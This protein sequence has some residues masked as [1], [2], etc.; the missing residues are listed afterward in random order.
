MKSYTEIN[1][2]RIIADLERSGLSR[3]E[4]YQSERFGKFFPEGT[5]QP[6]WSTFCNYT[7]Q[8][9]LQQRSAMRVAPVHTFTEQQ[10]SEALAGSACTKTPQTEGVDAGAAPCSQV[11]VRF[12]QGVTLEVDCR[13]PESLLL[14]ALLLGISP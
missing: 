8:I 12:P 5:R 7:V 11:R 3:R 14:N 10:V 1:W 4:Y 6:A 2:H 13:D 9:R